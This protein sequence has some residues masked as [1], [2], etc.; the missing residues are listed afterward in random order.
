MLPLKDRMLFN[1]NQFEQLFQEKNL[2]K[3]LALF[4]KGEV[5]PIATTSVSDFILL[6]KGQELSIKLK[7]D[8][9]MSFKCTC[10]SESYCQ[11]LSAALFYLQ[12]DTFDNQLKEPGR[13]KLQKEERL[14][15]KEKE[16]QI[17]NR[18]KD[19]EK[20]SS[21]ISKQN[22]Q[23][24]LRELKPL[25]AE[26]STLVA[27]DMYGVLIDQLLEPFR[28]TPILRPT[29]LNAILLQLQRYI[30]E[31]KRQEPNERIHLYLALSGAF[32]QLFHFRL[33][34][35]NTQLIH[36]FEQLVFELELVSE[37]NIDPDT[38]EVWF[39][40][41]MY[42]IE[43]NKHLASRVFE[44]LLPVWVAKTK[45]KQKLWHLSETLS[46]RHLKPSYSERFD[47][48]L[49]ARLMVYLRESKLFKVSLPL[50]G[51]EDTVEF[52]IAKAE[53][54]FFSGKSARAFKTLETAYEDIKLNKGDYYQEY[55]GY[56]LHQAKKRKRSD[57]ELTYLRESFING[58]FILP[59][60]L[61]Y[62]LNLLPENERS[63]EIGK[64]LALIKRNPFNYS[65][66]KVVVL[67]WEDKRWDELIVE[68]KKHKNKFQL[69]N[70]VLLKK[71]PDYSAA[72]LDLY[73]KHLIASILEK[74][75]YPYQ[76]QL[77]NKALEYLKKLPEQET[78]PFVTVVLN[79]LLKQSQ[80]YRYI[81]TEYDLE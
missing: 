28:S 78:I 75:F 57:L 44:A 50:I 70:E 68:L 54:D 56:L 36:L 9:V 24:F 25:L 14:F 39:R 40:A 11:H 1:I 17:K 19:L 77:F 23:V 64:L 59:E 35:E 79:G 52:I 33:A 49:Q 2:K 5:D 65:H 71:L 21:F 29:D 46:K 37:R 53:L 12:R 69:L 73:A 38:D 4:L 8:K 72:L 31:N 47:K 32:V 58:L 76:K 45:D 42:S 15:L 43:S 60:R 7:G 34:G 62:F 3:G 41:L 22:R 13:I 27:Y 61:Q 20:L 81:K 10:Q 63:N 16:K 26:N 6:I 55:L 30:D 67:L 18:K 74:E 66:D 51:G 80:I 48:L